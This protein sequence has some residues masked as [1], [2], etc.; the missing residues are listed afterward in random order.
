[1]A[2]RPPSDPSTLSALTNPVPGWEFHVR[3]SDSSRSHVEVRAVVAPHPV[4]VR[5]IRPALIPAPT[6]STGAQHLRDTVQRMIDDAMPP[7][8]SV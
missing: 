2:R 6:T 8:A 7:P 1:M 3:S 4:Q 5:D